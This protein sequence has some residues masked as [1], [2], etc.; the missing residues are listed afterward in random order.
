MT[1]PKQIFSSCFE[2]Q[3][4]VTVSESKFLG[5]KQSRKQTAYASS[6][7]WLLLN[8]NQFFSK[9]EVTNKPA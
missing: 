7:Q 2:Q 4:I 1:N 9:T 5:E 6:S 8:E 3:E